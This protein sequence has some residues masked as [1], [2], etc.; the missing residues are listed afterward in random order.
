M[1]NVV[2]YKWQPFEGYRS[3]FGPESVNT[4]AAMVARHYAGPHRVWC[5]TDDAGGINDAVRTLPLSPHLSDVP[6]PTGPQRNPSCYRR[7][8]VFSQEAARIIGGRIVLMDLDCVI[9]GDLA[10][11]F[12]CSEDFV[13]WGDTRKDNH[14]NGSMVMHR[15]GTHT[16][17]WEDFDPRLSPMKTRRAGFFGSDQGWISYKLGNSGARFTRRDGVYSYRNDISR[18]RRGT[19]GGKLPPG[20]RIVFF[21]GHVDP[22]DY[23]AQCLEWVKQHYR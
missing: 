23:E 8:W 19:T 11:L 9:T 21:H 1:I 4:L 20:A 5:V 12:E 16:Q 6:N 15:A 14:Y 10:P 7:L 17:L 3:K 2:T 18:G 13:A 22:W